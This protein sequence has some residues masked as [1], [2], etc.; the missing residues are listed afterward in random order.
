[1]IISYNNKILGRNNLIV[2]YDGSTPF[3]QYNHTTF[4]ARINGTLYWD[5]IGGT[6]KYF[7]TSVS[8]DLTTGTDI[9]TADPTATY[10][11]WP[12]ITVT[13]DHVYELV[14]SLEDL[15]RT[16][17][18]SLNGNGS[19]Y[20]NSG[21]NSPNN[22]FGELYSIDFWYQSGYNYRSSTPAFSNVTVIP[23]DSRNIHNAQYLT[24]CSNLFKNAP[25]TCNIIP[26]I[27]AL[28]AAAPN[29]TTTSGCFNGCTTAPD[30]AAALAQY[31]NW[32]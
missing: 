21:T 24:T 25:L 10:T 32:F 11:D 14:W 31:P 8:K 26:F 6:K 22:I 4:K 27:E 3:I 12:C 17:G 2:G 20:A 5:P 29:L 1:M 28:T 13:Q 7:D 23:Q 30:Y 16:F 9:T 18:N 19:L 15:Q